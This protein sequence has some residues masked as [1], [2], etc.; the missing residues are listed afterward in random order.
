MEDQLITGV[1]LIIFFLTVSVASSIILKK[2]H[3]P[4]TIGLVVVGVIFGLLAMRYE[5]LSLL[6]E[7]DLSPEL[8]L[9]IILPTLIFDAAIDIDTK[10]LFKNIIPIL[11]LAVLGLLI[12]TALIGIGISATTKLALSGALVYGALISA[13]DPVAVIALFKEIGAP[14]RLMTL[15]DGESLFNDATA[16]VLFSILIE[17]FGGT[18]EASFSLFHSIINFLV[19]LSGGLLVGSVIGYIGAQMLKVEK[20]SVLLQVTVSLIMAYVSFIVADHFL[21]VSGVMSTLAAG[22]IIQNKAGDVIKRSN[23]QT[24]EHFWEYFA[25][26]ANSFVFLLLGLTE[27]NRFRTESTFVEILIGLFTIVPIILIARAVGIYLLIPLY[28]KFVKNSEKKA[29]PKSYQTILFWGG[30]RGAVPIALVLAIPKDFAHR[31]GI[32][33]A[34]LAYILFTLLI[35]GTTIKK[36]MDFF[37]IKPERSAFDDENALHRQYPLGS[38][39]LASLVT[40]EMRLLFEDEGFFIRE[41][42]DESNHTYELLMKRNKIMILVEQEGENLSVTAQPEDICYLNRILYETLLGLKKSVEGIKKAV[43]VKKIKELLAVDVEKEELEFD[44]MQFIKPEQ[45]CTT[46]ESDTKNDLIKELVGKLQKSGAV[47]E[48]DNVLSEVMEREKSMTT[49]LGEGIAM[50]HAR[51]EAVSEVTAFIGISQKGVDFDALD[52]KPVHIFVL[53]LSPKNDSGPHLQFLAEMTKLLANEEVRKKV[54]A[55][56]SNDDLYELFRQAVKEN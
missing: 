47:A 18:A 7:I 36:L 9:Y 21:H 12:S 31:G 15:I 34:T 17:M 4:Y 48:S 16:I 1:I 3:F 51:T 42:R 37:Q 29:I 24:I 5:S 11:L 25:F 27:V 19:V 22:L 26:V 20:G 32:I 45:I 44:L 38:I 46:L 35:Q 6:N 8:I 56:T 52:K 13:T 41:K 53:I 40:R 28:N 14:K 54:I 49:A 55:E 43:N 23:I 2:I 33:N 39:S 10:T 30:L 50:P